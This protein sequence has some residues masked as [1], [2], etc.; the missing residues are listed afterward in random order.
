MS[1]F[2]SVTKSKDMINYLI[3]PTKH[4]SSNIKEKCDCD[5]MIQTLKVLKFDLKVTFS[6]I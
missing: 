1:L 4:D 6:E 2:N 3:L 5:K